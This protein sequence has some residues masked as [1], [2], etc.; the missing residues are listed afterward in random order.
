MHW[1]SGHRCLASNPKVAS[2]RP[3]VVTKWCVLCPYTRHFILSQSTQMQL[4]TS[5][6]W[7]STCDGLV[8]HPRGVNDS[9]P[10]ST[11]ETGDMCLHVSEK[12]L[13]F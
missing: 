9:H 1:L 8:S 10:L 12:K 3:A 7:G 2:L 6:C 5:L 11:N 13:T 4:G